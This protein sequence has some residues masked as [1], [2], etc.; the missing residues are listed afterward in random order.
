M[1]TS[2]IRLEPL[3]EGHRE[4]LKKSAAIDFMWTSMPLIASGTSFEAYFDHTLRMAQLGTGQGMA[5][6]EKSSG[7]LI[8][9]AAFL[10]PNR[11]HRRTRIGYTWID[12]P[13]RGTGMIDHIQLLMLRRSLGWRAR[14]VEWL[15]STRNERAIASVEKLG[16]TREGLLRQHSRFADGSW[17][18]LVILSLIGEEIVAAVSVLSAR[19]DELV[20]VPGA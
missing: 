19:I 7:N 16:A 1:E 18:D 4:P 9:L 8:G 17:A 13:Y 3:G 14:R 10:V 5:A 2:R 11:L 15:L 20:P 12:Q 6:V